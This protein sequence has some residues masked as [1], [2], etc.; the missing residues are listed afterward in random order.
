MYSCLGMRRR[1]ASSSSSGRLVAPTRSTRRSPLGLHPSIWTSI[2]VFIRLLASCSPSVLRADR[3]ESISSMKMTLL[4]K[5]FATANRAR[6]IFSP[7]PIH[8]EVRDEAEMLKKVALMLEA[9]AR[10]IKVLPVP[11]GPNN[12]RPFGGARAPLN[13]CGFCMG[14]TMISCTSFFAFSSPAMSSQPVL[15]PLSKISLHTISTILGSSFSISGGTWPSG[16]PSSATT[17]SEN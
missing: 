16:P 2:S 4:A 7:S 5:Q 8:F 3:M 10:P 12:R 11:G 17:F 6:T 1:A 9:I 14:Q 13:S 15:L